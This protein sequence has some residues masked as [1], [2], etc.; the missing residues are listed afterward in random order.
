M[1]TNGWSSTREKYMVELILYIKLNL[2]INI[3]FS[4]L[5]NL[6]IN[7]SIHSSLGV[8]NVE[9]NKCRVEI[10]PSEIHVLELRTIDPFI[11]YNYEMN[12]DVS[13]NLF[14]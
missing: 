4:Q 12:V 9:M 8:A 2:L 11:E 6:F 14:N 13:I 3:S 5:T 7:K 1:G 10:K